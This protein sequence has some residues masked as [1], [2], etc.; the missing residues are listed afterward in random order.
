MS[1]DAFRWGATLAQLQARPTWSARVSRGRQAYQPNPRGSVHAGSAT[2][3]VLRF[4]AAHPG[5]YFSNAELMQATGKS[6][7]AV[8]CALIALRRSERVLTL[9]DHSRKGWLRYALCVVSDGTVQPSQLQHC[10]PPK[11]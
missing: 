10:R 5:R 6:H 4:L 1:D 8:A 11:I 9:D 7:S 3:A 2:E